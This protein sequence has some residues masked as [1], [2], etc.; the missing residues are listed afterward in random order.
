MRKHPDRLWF[1]W[2]FDWGQRHSQLAYEILKRD[3]SGIIPTDHGRMGAAWVHGLETKEGEVF[4]PISHTA[5]H[6][7]IIGTTGAGKTRL[8]DI[9]VTQA[10][11]RG[12]AVIVIDPKGD[13]DL[14]DCA[15][16]ACRLSGQPGRFVHFHPA[17]PENSVRLDPLR[18]FNRSSEVA[19]RIA[20]VIPGEGGSDPFKAFGQKSL[21]NIV[22]GLFA[23]EQRPTLV[24][25]RRYLE[26]GSATLVVRALERYFDRVLEDGWKNRLNLKAKDIEGRATILVRHYRDTVQAIHP[27]MDLE[28]LV[29][30]FE[31]DR[32][33]FGKMVASL[34]PVMNMLTSGTL[35]PLLSPDPNDIDDTRPITDSARIINQAQVAYIG[36]DSLSDGMV[37]SAIGSILLAD[38][39][40]VAGDRYNYGVDNR[41]VNI[42]VDEAAEVINDP[43]IQLLNK[44]RGAK[45]R[46]SIAT[47]TFA[48]FAA[49]TGSEAKAR[50]I[51]GNVN[52]LI[53]LRVMDAE[54]QEYIT[55][56]LPKT[57]LKYIMRTQ[58]VSTHSS[59]P[60]VFS[61]NIGERLMEEESDLFAPQ[62][63]GQLPD[64]HY[65]AKLS[66][67]RIVKGRLP[68]LQ[69]KADE[70]ARMPSPARIA[71]GQR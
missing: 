63:L 49:R 64:L 34:L 4:Q 25:L 10:V 13:K 3:V 12:E 31:H 65:I 56:N 47:Q 46:L 36:L 39:A 70:N 43:C 45:F 48:D 53:A 2:G 28:G 66:G 21:D 40:S 38:L 68:V 20:S 19:S 1:G 44:G 35:G 9:L 51:L 8:F 41:P 52:N 5:G 17:F 26:G 30:M 37:G 11:L 55:D 71:N 23:L 42:F 67:G 54:T 61:G 24:K 69:S 27:N 57:R 59:N 29:S 32:T 18:N 7:L 33:H 6:T 22:Q 62:L 16:R 58:G 15:E 14:R 60:A 50:Q